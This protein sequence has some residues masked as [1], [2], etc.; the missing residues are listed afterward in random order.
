MSDFEK[1]RNL[2]DTSRFT[3]LYIIQMFLDILHYSNKNIIMPE[4]LLESHPSIEEKLR[5]D[6]KEI[7]EIANSGNHDQI[8]KLMNTYCSLNTKFDV[9]SRYGVVIY[10]LF[11]YAKEN[12]NDVGTF[13]S[14]KFRHLV[15]QAVVKDLIPFNLDIMHGDH[16]WT[17]IFNYIFTY[18]LYV[19]TKHLCLFEHSVMDFKPSI[20][21]SNDM[22]NDYIFNY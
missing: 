3:P 16:Y 6:L 20:R 22:K 17:S 4:V 13:A 21:R 2:G 15:N 19:K 7:D 11:G 8:I 12:I 18:I 9:M 5:E 14:I 10:L 1:T